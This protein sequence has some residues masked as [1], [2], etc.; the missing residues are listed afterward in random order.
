MKNMAFR[1]VLT[2]LVLM[3]CATELT[4]L[5]DEEIAVLEPIRTKIRARGIKFYHGDIQLP[6][7]RYGQLESIINTVN[8]EEASRLIASSRKLYWPSF[9]THQVCLITAIIAGS[10]GT[11]NWNAFARFDFKSDTYKTVFIVGGIGAIITPFFIKRALDNKFK[12]IERYN[13]V[14]RERFNVCLDFTPASPRLA[15]AAKF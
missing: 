9:I 13:Q 11:E 5:T 14:L 15:L 2:G 3:V 12:A 4:A 7:V 8:D 1:L 6:K 10:E